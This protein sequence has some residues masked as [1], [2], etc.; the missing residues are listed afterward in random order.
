MGNS[1]EIPAGLEPTFLWRVEKRKRWTK[2]HASA[3]E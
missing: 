1:E 3:D 2:K